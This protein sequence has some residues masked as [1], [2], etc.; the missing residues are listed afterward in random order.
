MGESIQCWQCGTRMTLDELASN[1]GDCPRCEVEVHLAEY[2]DNAL[3]KVAALEAENA[4][5][6][7]ELERR[8]PDALLSEARMVISSILDECDCDLPLELRWMA[9][10]ASKGRRIY[11]DDRALAAA[12]SAP[13]ADERPLYTCIGKGGEYRYMGTAI[14]AGDSRGE[15]A[16]VYQDRTGQL[17]HRT[18]EDF[19]ERMEPIAA[20]RQEGG[21]V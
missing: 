2:L 13:K 12:P 10:R 5:L 7:A 11:V 3:S 9:E 20:A 17:F 16:E 14:G 1:D 8:V 4:K 21:K 19:M 6:R 18:P 15:L